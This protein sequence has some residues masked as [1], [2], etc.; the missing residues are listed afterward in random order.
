MSSALGG[1]LRPALTA[2]SL[3]AV[4]LLSGCG[5]E[6]TADGAQQAEGHDHSDAPVVSVRVND[7]RR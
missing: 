1:R 4:V 5:D 3:T 2:L 7:G 6:A